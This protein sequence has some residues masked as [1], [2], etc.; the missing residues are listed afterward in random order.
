MVSDFF[1]KEPTFCC[2]FFFFFYFFLGGGGV[3]FYYQLTRNL[4]LTKKSFFFYF[5]FLWREESREGEGKCTCMNKCFKW[6]FYSERRTPVQIFF[7]IHAY[8]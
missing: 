4:Y 1:D 2:C 3:I 6:R 8:M 5:F 7:E